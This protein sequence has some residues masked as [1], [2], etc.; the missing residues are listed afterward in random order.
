MG[1]YIGVEYFQMIHYYYFC[2]GI[3]SFTAAVVFG[4]PYSILFMVFCILHSVISW[5]VA[6]FMQKV[7]KRFIVI[8]SSGY[9]FSHFILTL[10]VSASTLLL[11]YYEILIERFLIDAVIQINFFVFFL[12]LL[13]YMITRFNVAGEV[14][15]YF[16][17]ISLRRAKSL[18]I[19]KRDELG[20]GRLIS[21]VRIKSYRP[22]SDPE[23]DSML[24]SVWKE[25]KSSLPERIHEFEVKMCEKLIENF[26]NNIEKIKSKPEPT[27]ADLKILKTYERFILEYEK[28]SMEYE[29][30][31]RKSGRI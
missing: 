7:M 15:E 13:W 30:L 21:D 31:F 2:M 22:G 12:G 25:R 16:D 3:F 23:I 26:R 9:M 20:L 14:F 18:I 19:S 29:K 4:F 6:W 27:P 8:Q 10:V 11:W 28:N 1:I 24:I 17:E 5:Y